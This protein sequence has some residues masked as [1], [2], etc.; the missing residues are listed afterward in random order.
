MNNNEPI[1][2]GKVKKSGSSKPILVIIIFLFIGSIILFIPTI[3]NYF[4]DYNVIDLIK[5]GEIIDFIIN[6]DSYI[7]KG[8][9]NDNK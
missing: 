7:K 2:L 1:V 6:H 8:T 3:S 5:N 4:E 9:T